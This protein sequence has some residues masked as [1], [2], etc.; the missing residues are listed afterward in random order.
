MAV[1]S[2]SS[3]EAKLTPF[4]RFYDHSVSRNYLQKSKIVKFVLIVHLIFRI[5][6]VSVIRQIFLLQFMI[7]K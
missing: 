1:V 3:I 6:R 4:T 7:E 5:V 2:L